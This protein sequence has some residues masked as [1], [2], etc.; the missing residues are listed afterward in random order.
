MTRG[1]LQYQLRLQLLPLCLVLFLRHV[2][3]CSFLFVAFFLFLVVRLGK[4][5]TC[6]YLMPK[7]LPLSFIAVIKR[8]KKKKFVDQDTWPSKTKALG[9][10][11][12]K[13]FQ[14]PAVF[15][16]NNEKKTYLCFL[17]G[18]IFF[19]RKTTSFPS[20]HLFPRILSPAPVTHFAL[21]FMTQLGRRFYLGLLG[22][23]ASATGV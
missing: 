14:L 16:G 5:L 12:F 13:I 3:F 6:S 9:V 18:P 23:W 20:R 17:V 1:W 4:S 22:V 19:V 8:W 21:K 7:K 10:L 11:L 15:L 2:C